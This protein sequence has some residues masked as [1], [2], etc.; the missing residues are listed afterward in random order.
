MRFSSLLPLV[1]LMACAPKPD[2]ARTT[3][4]SGAT[5]PD[6]TTRKVSV[7]EGFSTPESVLWDGAQGVWFVSNINGNP[8]AKDG[9]GF[10]SRLKTDGT[11]DSLHFIAGGTGGVTLNG[12]KGLAVTGDTLWVADIDAVR[13]FNRLTGAPVATIALGK[14]VHFLND[15]V[16]GPDGTLYVTDTGV[17]FDA[18]GNATHPG[19]DRIYAVRGGKVTVAAEGD[20][21]GWPNGITWDHNTQ[22]FVV[23][24]FGGKMVRSWTAGAATGDT[25]GTGPGSQDGVEILDGVALITSWA[26]STVFA[27][28]RGERHVVIS[29]VNA[30]ADIGLDASHRMLAIPLFMDNRVEFWRVGPLR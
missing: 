19:P 6:T 29:G 18:K 8:S 12:P 30:P 22:R 27:L 5:P 7:T 3:I 14:P 25:L 16:A 4:D 23:V 21:L 11:I 24:P 9:N 20:W 17:L 10:I 13:G 15:I 28:H 1:A 26:D 2:E